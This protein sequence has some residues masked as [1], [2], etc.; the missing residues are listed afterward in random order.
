MSHRLARLI[1]RL[2]PLRH[3]YVEPRLGWL[4]DFS[5]LSSSP[6]GGPERGRS[7]SDA[8][9]TLHASAAGD[10]RFRSMPTLGRPISRSQW[11]AGFGA[12]SGPS[13][14]DPCR[15]AIR[16]TA[17]YAARDL[18]CPLHVDSRQLARL[19]RPSASGSR[20]VNR[21]AMAIRLKKGTPDLR[22]SPS[23]ECVSGAS[24][25]RAAIALQHAFLYGPQ[26]LSRRYHH[27]PS[28]PHPVGPTLDVRH[29]QPFV[30]APR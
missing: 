25:G 27:P 30:R 2:G 16:P 23:A 17:T 21:L 4:D 1:S 13:R 26:N 10:W 18:L 20:A 15:R 19:R 11:N 6:S 29:D 8:S 7:A 3:E 24:E 5:A 12:D 9:K 14:S 22:A 28:G